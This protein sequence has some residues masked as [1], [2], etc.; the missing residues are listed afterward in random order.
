MI[1]TIE[2]LPAGDDG[3]LRI[4][5]EVPDVPG[6]LLFRIGDTEEWGSAMYSMRKRVVKGYLPP[7]RPWQPNSRRKRIRDAQARGER[8]FVSL[9]DEPQADTNQTATTPT[10]KTPQRRH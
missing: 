3:L 6:V 5:G 10:R 7:P 1:T 2:L 9:M 8:V 4:D